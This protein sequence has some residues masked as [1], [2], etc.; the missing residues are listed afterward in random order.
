MART[1]RTRKKRPEYQLGIARERIEILMGLAEKE[2]RKHPERSRRYVGLA[3]KIGMR[4][5]VRL[6]RG[7]KRRFCKG[8]NTLL[9]PGVTS[10][11]RTER[12]VIVIKC[13]NCNKIYRY[14][15]YT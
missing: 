5:N 11:Q 15:T 12:G 2:F 9:K 1:V 10:S 8:C 4:Y 14:S 3:R 13:L 7:Q 6:G